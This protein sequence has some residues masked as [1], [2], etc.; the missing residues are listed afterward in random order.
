[1][2][3]LVVAFRRH[4]LLPLD[5]CLYAVK[6]TILRLTR[7]SLHRC[8]QRHGISRLPNVEGDE[9]VK[10][11]F[12]TYPIGC[13]HIDIAEVQTAEGKLY[14]YVATDRTSKFAFVKLLRKDRPDFSLRVPGGLDRDCS[15]QKHTV[16]LADFIKAHNFGRRPKTLKGL[17][18]YEHICKSGQPSPNGSSSIQ[19]TKCRD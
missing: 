13:F 1:M 15:L 12:E 6:P 8:L 14:L 4:T 17:T 16:I 5:D 18:P 11:K 2:R 7:S 10:N 3:K 9:R 19:S